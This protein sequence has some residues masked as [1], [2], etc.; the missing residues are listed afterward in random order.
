MPNTSSLLATRLDYQ[1]LRERGV[2]VQPPHLAVDSL[3]RKSGADVFDELGG[4]LLI[5]YLVSAQVGRFGEGDA[6]QHYTSPTPYTPSQAVSWRALPAVRRRRLYALLPDPRLIDEIRGPQWVVGPGGIQY[7]LPRGFPQ[8]AI[9]VPGPPGL[10]W[11][12]VV[13]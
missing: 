1:M 2:T 5:R 6:G 7:V 4:R 8:R 10:H 11:E 13:E 3:P 12:I 9:V